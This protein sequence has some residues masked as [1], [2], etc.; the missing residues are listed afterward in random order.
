MTST[1][2]NTLSDVLKVE[3]V[4]C[5]GFG[6]VPKAVMHD[7]ELTLEAKAIYAYFCAFAGSGSTLFPGR[8]TILNDLGLSKKGY[9]SHYKLLLKHG[10]IRVAKSVGKFT[11]NTYV[12]ESNPKKLIENP[13]NTHDELKTSLLKSKGYGTIPRAVMCDR[14]LDIK[15]KGIYAYL[16]SY[17]GAG[18]VAFPQWRHLLHHLQISEKTYYKYYGQLIDCNYISVEQRREKG[19][20]RINDYILNELPDEEKTAKAPCG[21]KEDTAIIEDS[22][23]ISPYSKK[24]DTIINK[25]NINSFIINRSINPSGTDESETDLDVIDG[26]MDLTA[27]KENILTVRNGLDRLSAKAVIYELTEWEFS[28]KHSRHPEIFALAADCMVEMVSSAKMSVYCGESVS[29][30][31]VIARLDRCVHHGSLTG[32]MDW[33]IDEY[34]AVR[35]DYRIHAP[36]PHMKSCLWTS[37][38]AYPI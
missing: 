1:T 22:A 18:T 21:K 38:G 19:Q 35:K 8:E 24:E 11:H 30:E 37:M 15:A 3:G 20:Y 25:G 10:Y 7:T 33:F 14:R 36:I 4:N 27:E 23:G 32:F 34:A 5:M 16:A 9:Y 17:T 12:L 28:S 29:C 31:D 26:L 13:K 2:H 6:T